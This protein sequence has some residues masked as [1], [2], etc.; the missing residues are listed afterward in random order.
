LNRYSI[1]FKLSEQVIYDILTNS[2]FIVRSLH[3]KGVIH[4]DIKPENF[5]LHFNEDCSFFLSLCDFGLSQKGESTTKSIKGTD[6]LIDPAFII[7]GKLTYYSD[8]WSLAIMILQLLKLSTKFLIVDTIAANK[9]SK[10]P[11]DIYNSI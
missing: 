8:F 6:Q 9:K 10:S 11:S 1:Y 7:E 5:L 4:S 2:L 3:K